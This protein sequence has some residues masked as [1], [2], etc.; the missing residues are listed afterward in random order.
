MRMLSTQ[1][2]QAATALAIA[3]SFGHTGV[4]RVLIEKGGADLDAQHP[5][6]GTTPL[7]WAAEMGRVDAIALL[8]EA[9]AD[10]EAKKD[11]RH[12]LHTGK[13]FLKSKHERVLFLISIFCFQ[14][15]IQINRKQLSAC[16]C[17]RLKYECA[18]RG[19]Y[20]PSLS[21]R[22]A[23]LMMCAKHFFFRV[24]IQIL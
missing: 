12:A 10:V 22:A 15:R 17:V 4:M 2:V 6:A 16:R 14:R 7:H 1:A 24:P 8:C 18:S 5:F 21:R 20:Q 11:R 19:R 3:S 13:F 9:G 23:S